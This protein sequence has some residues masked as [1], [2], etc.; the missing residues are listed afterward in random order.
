[1]IETALV[2]DINGK[3]ICFTLDRGLYQKHPGEI[4]GF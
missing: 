2:F 1:M 4:H 3:T